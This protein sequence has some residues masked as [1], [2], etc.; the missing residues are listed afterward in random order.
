MA[1]FCGQRNERT[2]WHLGAMGARDARIRVFRL[3][4]PEGDAFLDCAGD[5]MAK[6]KT[7]QRRR[8]KRVALGHGVFAVYKDK[9]PKSVELHTP[10]VTRRMLGDK[11]MIGFVRAFNAAERMDAIVDLYLL[12]TK[13]APR[14]TLRRGRNERF[15]IFLMHALL[16]E[17]LDAVRALNGAIREDLG[18]F[19]PWLRLR[20]MVKRWEGDA[21]L[22]AFRHQLGHHLGDDDLIVRG[23]DRL[24]SGA[25][26]VVFDTEGQG[27][28]GD[29]AYPLALDVLLRGLGID[30]AD[31]R[32]FVD[33]AQDDLSLFGECVQTVFCEVLRQK[34]VRFGSP[35]EV[36]PR[37]TRKAHP[38]RR[39]ANA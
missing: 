29:S 15:L 21:I 33:D 32:K 13:L 16:Y 20:K 11:L 34:G 30:A 39:A 36:P 28:R 5:R 8:I 17:A 22:K 10:Q 14:I 27:V 37:L 26:I 38:T 31:F 9:R 25:H 12:S 19:E 23:L 6:T 4:S 18:D 1:P 24:E 35:E 3:G 2:R 7:E